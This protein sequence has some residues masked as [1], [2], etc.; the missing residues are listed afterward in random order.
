MLVSLVG[1]KSCLDNYITMQSGIDTG[2]ETTVAPGTNT[3]V[4]P[5]DWKKKYPSIGGTQPK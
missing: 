3:E 2:K 1:L 5:M 4:S